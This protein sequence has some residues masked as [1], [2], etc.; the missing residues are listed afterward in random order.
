MLKSLI[1]FLLLICQFLQ[2]FFMPGNVP[3]QN[4]GINF[5]SIKTAVI[6]GEYALGDEDPVITIE[7]EN[8]VASDDIDADMFELTELFSA[9]EITDVAQNGE[10]ITLLTEGV[11]PYEIP[12]TGGVDIS[13]KATESATELR[14]ECEL[15]MRD[16]YIAQDSFALSDGALDFD[17]V[18]L[19]GTFAFAVGDSIE[20]N[21]LA[22]TVKNVSD[23]GTAV[24]LTVPT[25]A[26][27][28]DSAVAQVD[29]KEILI[30]ADKLSSGIAQNVLIYANEAVFGATVSRIVKAEKENTYNVTA[31]LFVKNGV[32]ADDLAIADVSLG[33]AF[34]DATIT[35]LTKTQNAY[36]LN[37]T[38]EKSGININKVALEGSVTVA[39]GKVKNLWNTALPESTTALNYIRDGFSLDGYKEITAY[40]PAETGIFDK[41]STIGSYIG[42]AA[43]VAGGVVTVLEM[44]G[45][46]E[47]TDAKVEDTRRIVKEVQEALVA[48]DRKLDNIGSTITAGT[49]ETMSA[50]QYNTYITASGNWDH[51]LGSYVTPLQK[52]LTEFEMAY[53]EYMLNYIMNAHSLLHTI[54][55]WKDV[56]GNVTLPH[57]ANG[58]NST[59]YSVDGK[60]LASIDAHK[61]IAELKGVQAKVMQNGGRLYDGYW[62]DIAAE[63]NDKQFA[64]M[65]VDITKE[66]YL[67]AV[68]MNA[69]LH[70][71]ETAG[72]SD[73]LNAFTSLCNAL[74]GEGSAGGL[75]PLDNYLTMLSM[76]YNFY[77]ESAKDI[78]TTLTW[79]YSILTEGAFVSTMAYNFTPSAE[80]D[81][82][83][84]SFDK[85]AYQITKASAE[86][87]SYYSYVANK[88]LTVAEVTHYEGNSTEGLVQ[89]HETELY[90][91][92]CWDG[93]LIQPDTFR[94][95]MY[96]DEIQLR[97]M[98]K[99]YEYLY[100]AGVCDDPS[101]RHYLVSLGLVANNVLFDSMGNNLNEVMIIASPIS[102]DDIPLDNSVEMTVTRKW[103]STWYKPGDVITIGTQGKVSKE[104][105]VSHFRR[106]ADTMDFDGNV[107]VNN[108]ILAQAEYNESHWYW[109]IG[110]AERWACIVTCPDTML[111][112]TLA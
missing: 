81:I 103:E 46:L 106:C 38:F 95:G 76:Y 91:G 28:L 72:A 105:Y 51:F 88:T 47:S 66:E 104:Y 73:I 83:N 18:C 34:E 90:L 74:A 99:R 109:G 94:T 69:T 101:F 96:M 27:D 112:F 54:T 77:I 53:N 30:P 12:L 111:M 67:T 63:I 61:L 75:K 10:T 43:G 41:I 3:S 108:V 25:S 11:I 20:S 36:T 7:L 57:P 40:I 80:K 78:S 100:R 102:L 85:A 58:T 22:F 9:L 110:N 62:E 64:N 59:W 84:K 16:A 2:S 35:A 52:E 87:D 17:M 45:I 39:E 26:D 56:D 23:D 68:Q 79:L 70:A 97:L 48:L 13:A 71:L 60:V 49:V 19:N 4:E 65:F 98:I 5:D 6:T 82:V 107:T 21:G 29:G 55:V 32:W 8:T 33:G 44:V 89:S 42:T 15:L 24:T 31:V 1:S 86:K 14:A 93:K 37:F 50:V 92:S